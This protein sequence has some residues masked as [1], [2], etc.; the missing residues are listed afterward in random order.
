[1][2]MRSGFSRAGFTLVELLVVI[3]IIGTLVGLL[4]PA[5]QSAREAAR[6]SVC[7]ANAKN[8]GLATLNFVSAK[9]T[10]PSGGASQSNRNAG[11]FGLQSSFIGGSYAATGNNSYACLLGS[12]PRSRQF[13]LGVPGDSA[14]ASRGGP[15]YQTAPFNELMNEY[16]NIG[17]GTAAYASMPVFGCPSR[18]AGA[19]PLPGPSSTTAGTIATGTETTVSNGVA[20]TVGTNSLSNYLGTGLPQQWW[21]VGGGVAPSLQISSFAWNQQIAV[22]KATPSN[23]DET[24]LNGGFTSDATYGAWPNGVCVGWNVGGGPAA[25]VMALRKQ[26]DITDGTSTSMLIGEINMDNRTYGTGNLAYRDSAFSGGGEVSRCLWGSTAPN[27]QIVYPDQNTDLLG[28][29]NVRGYWGSAHPAGATIVMADGSVGKAAHG[30]DLAT[31][32]GIQDGLV[33]DQSLLG[34]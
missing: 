13:G 12:G 26:K 21:M 33:T 24:F 30:V 10:Y 14:N 6:A 15:G 11:T 34:R 3:A 16:N 22:D 5:V 23:K 4:L 2:K 32:V 1:M 9:G 31:F 7:T 29:T 19:D 25:Y 20:P 28:W 17:N 27:P 8:L 18:F